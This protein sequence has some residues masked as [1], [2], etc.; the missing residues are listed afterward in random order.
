MYYH[1]L[2]TTQL[3]VLVDEAFGLCFL[4]HCNVSWRD[5]RMRASPQSGGEDPRRGATVPRPPLDENSL[6]DPTTHSPPSRA[7]TYGRTPKVHTRP[8]FWNRREKTSM[9]LA[10]G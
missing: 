9:A 6:D 3:A 2:A 1:R 5:V 8:L 4:R 10:Q 7:S